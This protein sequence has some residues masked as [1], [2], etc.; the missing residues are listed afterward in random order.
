MLSRHLSHEEA[1]EVL[2]VHQNTVRSWL[3]R[4]ELLDL[5]EETVKALRSALYANRDDQGRRIA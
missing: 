3:A 1:A 2:G 5:R 4:G